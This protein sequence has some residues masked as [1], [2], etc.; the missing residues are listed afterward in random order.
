MPPQPS[1]FGPARV[2]AG[3][4][5]P[6][7]G[8]VEGPGGEQMLNLF[9]W[10]P[11]RFLVHLISVPTPYLDIDWPAYA[12]EIG[13]RVATVRS[14]RGVSQ[15][16]LAAVTGIS[17]SQ[18]QNIERSRTYNKPDAGNTTLYRLFVIAQALGVPVRL[19][20][21]SDV[22]RAEYRDSLDLNWT[23]IEFDLQ[24]TVAAHE[25]PKSTRQSPYVPRPRIRQHPVPAAS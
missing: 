5:L 20:I 7:G 15:T 3:L 18:I 11:K 23:Q 14:A 13:R 19:L 17:R 12:D 21:P 24:A 4:P 1:R 2:A 25:M 9:G 6:D 10:L 8:A 22:P 16:E